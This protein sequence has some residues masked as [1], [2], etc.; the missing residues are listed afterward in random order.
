MIDDFLDV[1]GAIFDLRLQ[2]LMLIME[3]YEKWETLENK[4]GAFK[5]KKV[6]KMPAIEIQFNDQ[7]EVVT[8]HVISTETE[9]FAQKGI[10]EETRGNNEISKKHQKAGINDALAK[11]AYLKERAAKFKKTKPGN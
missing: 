2:P 6:K 11:D 8:A 1:I 9:N 10:G 5:A 4:G 7:G 3:K